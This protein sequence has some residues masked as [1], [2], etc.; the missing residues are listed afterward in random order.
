MVICLGRVNN[1]QKLL[2]ARRGSGHNMSFKRSFKLK[3][4]EGGGSQFS[5]YPLD[6]FYRCLPRQADFDKD[7]FADENNVM[8]KLTVISIIIL[9]LMI[10]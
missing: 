2:K 4:P 3:R 7:I 9:L 6:V 10:A 1:S 5:H 8:L